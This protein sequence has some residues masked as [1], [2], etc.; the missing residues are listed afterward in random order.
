MNNK[1]TGN[2]M[3]LQNSVALDSNILKRHNICRVI[4][5]SIGKLHLL[6]CLKV[7]LKRAGK[8]VKNAEIVN[9]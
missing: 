9:Y 8:N 2:K 6:K 3:N 1:K 7:E 4:T 5:R